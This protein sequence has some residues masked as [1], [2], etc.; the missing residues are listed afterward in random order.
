MTVP[1]L[2]RALPLLALSLALAA[3]GS[4]GESGMQSETDAGAALPE[5][6]DTGVVAGVTV[7]TQGVTGVA[8]TAGVP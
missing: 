2:R 1:L 5:N 6:T 7:D 4:E 8:D 3:C